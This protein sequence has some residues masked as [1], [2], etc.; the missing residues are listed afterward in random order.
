MNVNGLRFYTANPTNNLTRSLVTMTILISI[1]KNLALFFRHPTTRE[2][3][4]RILGVAGASIVTL[5]AEQSKKNNAL[6]SNSRMR[7]EEEV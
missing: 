7:T 5:V 1:Q 3:L 2:F 6:Q 4:W